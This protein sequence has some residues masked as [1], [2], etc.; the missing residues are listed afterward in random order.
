MD[1]VVFL[2]VLDNTS[3]FTLLL[4]SLFFHLEWTGLLQP[5]SQSAVAQHTGWSS[6][7]APAPGMMV[8][9]GILFSQNPSIASY[10]DSDKDMK[11]IK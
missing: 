4:H 8:N 9:L 11:L 7:D 10:H 3:C 6:V 1:K 5:L 2:E